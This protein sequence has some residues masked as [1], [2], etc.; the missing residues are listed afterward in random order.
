MYNSVDGNLDDYHVSYRGARA[1]G[2]FARTFGGRMAITRDGHTTTRCGGIW[3]DDQIEGHDR[4]CAIIERMG[5][6]TAIQLGH[7]GREGS[8]IPP[9]IAV[10]EEGSWKQLPPEH[11]DGWTCRA[12]SAIPYGGGHVYPVEELSV[13]AIAELH[14]A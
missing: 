2:G 7:T 8:E 9:F 3:S 13:D 11:P 10:D 6:V 12:P 14:Q 1:G 4:I 5:G